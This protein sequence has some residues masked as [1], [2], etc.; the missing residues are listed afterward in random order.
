MTRR[1]LWRRCGFTLIELLVVIAIIGVLIG[2]LLPAVQKVREAANR[3][4]CTNNLKQMGIAVHN[5]ASSRDGQLPYNWFPLDQNGTWTL[6]AGSALYALLPFLEQ[7]NLYRGSGG[8]AQQTFSNAAST[9]LKVFTC[10]SDSSKS[11]IGG[12]WNATSPPNPVAWPTMVWING[13]GAAPS[14]S[15]PNPNNGN[16]PE[17]AGGNYIY[18]N[19]VLHSAA[20]IASTFPDGT[21]NTLMIAER[22]QN[23]FSN[24]LVAAGASYATTW[25][26]PW[27]ATFFAGGTV[28]SVGRINWPTPAGVYTPA[29]PPSGT[30]P[31]ATATSG[32]LRT[33]PTLFV[34]GGWLWQAQAG[35]STGNCLRTAFSAA[36]PGGVQALFAD[37]SVHSMPNGYDPRSLY[38][39][40]TPAGGDLWIGDF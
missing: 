1:S 21:S 6:A 39:V 15:P 33:T 20:N 34:G 13:T 29:P 16:P 37:G 32:Y 18:S 38:F 40:S 28:G 7:D 19:Q 11:N 27:T 25:A 3:M 30:I 36:H 8:A 9:P 24:S 10:P 26:D 35:A 14:T 22:I 5:F 4:V 2:L 23:C 12:M 31:A 17:F